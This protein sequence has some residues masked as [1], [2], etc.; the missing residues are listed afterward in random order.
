MDGGGLLFD[1][2]LFDVQTPTLKLG[3]YSGRDIKDAF[4]QPGLSTLNEDVLPSCCHAPL[5]RHDFHD[6][7]QVLWLIIPREITNIVFYTSS[8]LM[9]HCLD[10]YLFQIKIVDIYASKF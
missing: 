7:L 1:H 2:H 4:F 5:P 9:S 3:R 10:Y 8:F 6:P